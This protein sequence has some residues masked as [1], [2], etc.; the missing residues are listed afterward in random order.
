VLLYAWCR[1][2]DDVIDGQTLGHGHGAGAGTAAGRLALLEAQTGR[3]L[4][5]ET[6]LDPPFA[7]L[8]DVVREAAIPA[9][10]PAD[11]LAGFARDVAGAPIE[12]ADA[13]LRYCYHVA[14]GVG[15]MMA[16]A[17]GVSPDDRQTL[18]RACDLG[19]AFQLDNIARDIVEDAA[20]GRCYLPRRWLAEEGIAGAPD[21]VTDAAALYRLCGR[22]VDLAGPYRSSAL[23][24]TPALPWRSAW[25]VLAAT[26]IYGGIGR[27]RLALGPGRLAVRATVPAAAKLAAV[28]VALVQT[29][30]RRWLWPAP[31]PPRDGLWTAP[32]LS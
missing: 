17:M 19:I 15:I 13:L 21:P 28:P 12:D 18:A 8:A 1:H 20:I 32:A 27:R 11:L 16:I 25:A 9:C 29:L 30:G 14:G 3:A 22:L 24:G 7:A 6:G 4:A 31:H 10:Y 2:C 23:R 5:G 26:R